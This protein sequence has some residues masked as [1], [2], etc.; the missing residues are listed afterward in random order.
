MI[1][2]NPDPVDEAFRLA[3]QLR[4]DHPWYAPLAKFYWRLAFKTTRAL[5]TN[6]QPVR[7]R[8]ERKTVLN[9]GCGNKFYDHA[10][11]SDLFAPHRFVMRKRRPDLYWSGTQPLENF[12]GHFSGAVCEHVIEHMLPDDALALFRNL[13]HVLAPNG[14]LV[15][16]Y[17]DIRRVLAS[18]NCQGYQSRTV[19]MNAL[20]YRHEHRFMY[21]DEIV[22]TLLRLAGFRN[23]A[24]S[25]FE[26]LPLGQFLDPGRKA[27]SS[28]LVAT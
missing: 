23:A 25:S 6:I 1:N 26:E 9:F 5:E 7:S 15:I 2:S 8:N 18:G 12:K 14:T 24:T 22:T 19:S 27:E 10:V 4:G 21:D 20:I 11:N 3:R 13:R 28:Y 16:S 17:P